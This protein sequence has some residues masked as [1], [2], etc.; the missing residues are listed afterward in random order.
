MDTVAEALLT[1]MIASR[2]FSAATAS[3]RSFTYANCIA[4]SS[5]FDHSEPSLRLKATV[6]LS[7]CATSSWGYRVAWYPAW[8]ESN[9]TPWRS[10]RPLNDS[11]GKRTACVRGEMS[12][13]AAH[14][15][16][17]T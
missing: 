15:W 12:A 5:S 10:L 11:D 2:T 6:L 9:D 1:V 17:K 13:H 14:E 3:A 16:R 8:G 7:E 4:T